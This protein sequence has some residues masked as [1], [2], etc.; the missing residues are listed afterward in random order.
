MTDTKSVFGAFV[1]HLV[2]VGEFNHSSMV[3]S[4]FR[5]V[6]KFSSG[7]TVQYYRSLPTPCPKVISFWNDN[8]LEAPAGA[9]GSDRL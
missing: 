8:G 2:G 6:P 7:R 9:F 4:I 5:M 1:D 3:L